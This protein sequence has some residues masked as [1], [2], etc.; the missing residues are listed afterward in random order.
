MVGVCTA[1]FALQCNLANLF[2]AGTEAAGQLQVGLFQ[3]AGLLL[4]LSL[5]IW[6]EDLPMRGHH[7]HLK[8]FS[9]C[10]HSC[11]YIQEEAQEEE[12]SACLQWLCLLHSLVCI[13]CTSAAAIST[14]L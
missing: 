1:S 10:K 9:L 13:V 7:S 5:L 3:N 4:W 8:L 12:I 2:K 14:S 6:L 11:L